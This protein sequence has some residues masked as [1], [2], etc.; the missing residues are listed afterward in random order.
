MSRKYKTRLAKGEKVV[1]EEN[2]T[3]MLKDAGSDKVLVPQV[4]SMIALYYKAGA[5]EVNA[6][7]FPINTGKYN[8]SIFYK[9]G[10]KAR[11]KYLKGG[12]LSSIYEYNGAIIK[13]KD[14][15]AMSSINNAHSKINFVSRGEIVIQ[16]RPWFFDTVR[17]MRDSGVGEE[18]ALQAIRENMYKKALDD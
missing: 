17:K 13:P 16:P 1:C 18:A 9:G 6:R 3:K 14:K 10:P 5:R 2:V 11:N 8:R 12:Q 7:L 15:V 4:T